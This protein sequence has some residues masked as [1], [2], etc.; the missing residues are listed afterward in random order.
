MLKPY[1]HLMYNKNIQL[2]YISSLC[3]MFVG[4]CL[5]KLSPTKDL[6]RSKSL[7]MYS[8]ESAIV[9]IQLMISDL[10]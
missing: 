7:F 3:F 8:I 1:I 5:K 9:A 10:H 4:L 2:M 6:P